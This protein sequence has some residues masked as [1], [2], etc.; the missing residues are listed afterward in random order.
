MLEADRQFLLAGANAIILLEGN[1][2]ASDTVASDAWRDTVTPIANLTRFHR[3]VPILVGP[4]DFA[5]LPTSILPCYSSEAPTGGLDSRL[6]ALA[7][8][9]NNLAWRL[10]DS[11]AALVTTDGEIPAETDIGVLRA[12]CQRVREEIDQPAGGT[13]TRG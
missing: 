1:L 4:V 6:H 5:L 12:A 3:A 9:A 7:L 8:G 13:P 2:P 11:T 10:A